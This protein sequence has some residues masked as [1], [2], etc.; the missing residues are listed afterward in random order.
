MVVSTELHRDARY[1]RSSGENVKLKERGL[2]AYYV[3][4]YIWFG[5]EHMQILAVEVSLIAMNAS[6]LE[7]HIQF[8]SRSYSNQINR[9]VR[10]SFNIHRGSA[11]S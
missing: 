6:R 9:S 3:K 2:F 1:P 11:S 4:V 10:A 8:D 7:V 5:W